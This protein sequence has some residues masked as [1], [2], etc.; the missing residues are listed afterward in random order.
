MRSPC[1]KCPFRTDVK[2]YLNRERAQEI[3]SGL[4]PQQQTFACHETTEHDD[5]G[6]NVISEKEQ[7]CAGALIVLEGMNRPNQM[8]RLAERFGSYDRRKLSKTAPVF[9]TLRAFVAAQPV[10]RRSC[11]GVKPTQV[12]DAVPESA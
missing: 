9:K 12:V 5:D 3:S 2:P 6:E 8:M 7:H 1:P 11:K 4:F 10:R